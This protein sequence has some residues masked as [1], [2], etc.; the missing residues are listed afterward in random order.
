MLHQQQFYPVSTI[1]YVIWFLFTCFQLSLFGQE[2]KP[3]SKGTNMDVVGLPKAPPTNPLDLNVREPSFRQSGRDIIRSIIQNKQGEYVVIG[4]TTNRFLSTDDNIFFSR[5]N[6][7]TL[8]QIGNPIPI[9]D[10]HTEGGNAVV[11]TRDGGY[12]IAGFTDSVQVGKREAWLVKVSETGLRLWDTKIGTPENDEFTGIV[13]AP[14]GDLWMTGATNNKLWVVKTDA[15]GKNEKTFSPPISGNTLSSRGNGLTWA[16]NGRYLMVVGTQI[17]KSSQNPNE[18]VLIRFDTEGGTFLPQQT[19]PKAEGN[20]IVR[21]REGKFG[22]VG[23][24]YEYGR[25]DILFIYADEMGVSIFK[26]QFGKQNVYD[27]GLAIAQDLDGQFIV[28]G[29]FFEDSRKN[30]TQGWMHKVRKDGSEVWS[31][32]RAFGGSGSDAFYA[33]MASDS[34]DIVAVGKRYKNAQSDSWL[35]WMAHK[36]TPRNANN[37]DIKITAGR[38]HD[39]ED[40]SVLRKERRGFYEF[41]IENPNAEDVFGLVANIK[42]TKDAKKAAFSFYDNIV[43]GTLRGRERRLIT[44]PFR[45]GVNL[46]RDEWDFDIQFTALRET[47]SDVRH[48]FH[49]STRD[50]FKY[51]LEIVKNTLPADIQAGQQ[52]RFEFS[53]KNNGDLVAQNVQLRMDVLAGTRIKIVGKDLTDL[54]NI[55]AGETKTGT[56]VFDVEKEFVSALLFLPVYVVVNG[57]KKGNEYQ[58]TARVQNDRKGEIKMA[59]NPVPQQPVVTKEP[60][61]LIWKNNTENAV[62][63]KPFYPLEL[64]VETDTEL[65]RREHIKIF[66]G[67][68]ESTGERFDNVRLTGGEPGGLYKHRYYLKFEPSIPI[69]KT[70]IKVIVN[71]GNSPK[72]AL[73]SIQRVNPPTLYVL[74]VG[75]DYSSNKNGIVALNYTDRDAFSIDSIFKTQ[76][77]K[78]KLFEKVKTIAISNDIQTTGKYIKEQLSLLA[79]MCK[80]N[81]VFVVL[82]SGHGGIPDDK[83]KTIRFFGSDYDPSVS[84]TYLDYVTEIKPILDNCKGQKLLFLDACQKRLDKSGT[85]DPQQLSEALERVIRA[86]PTFRALLSCSQQEASWESHVYKHGAFTQAILEA[87]RG[88]NVVCGDNDENCNANDPTGVESRNRFLTF[89]ELARFVKKRVPMIVKEVSQPQNPTERDEHPEE[90]IPLFWFDK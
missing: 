63:T 65:K 54:G 4:T 6:A 10:R 78:G 64:I 38:F 13:E 89:Q 66:F 53:V 71:D 82:L 68:K 37:I 77:S 32:P 57:A 34:N 50:E 84:S 22:V 8:D 18:L 16:K 20:G 87:L 5:L 51:Q 11:Q 7:N 12:V 61:R 83:S 85:A 30:T 33:A 88:E 2:P 43:I 90:D 46:G 72:Y 79:S 62:V 31:N 27:G 23:T 74:S 19:V 81:D 26:K 49:L 42:P 58:L 73:F 36:A 41:W 35:L 28:L 67:G 40:K 17:I 56:L 52:V 15:Q 9:G 75:V 59:N 21:D 45:S 48:S 86:T 25:G 69:G 60:I 47:L 1:R 39:N 80:E 14:N 76:Q 55:E 3:K 24:S 70:D 44:V 29:E